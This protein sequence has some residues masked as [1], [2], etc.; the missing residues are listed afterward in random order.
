MKTLPW[1]H[2]MSPIFPAAR[3]TER[4]ELNQNEQN[5][6]VPAWVPPVHLAF[7]F[8]YSPPT[9][10]RTLDRLTAYPEPSRTKLQ[11]LLRGYTRSVIMDAW[12][13]QRKG[14]VPVDEVAAFQAQLVL[15]EPQTKGQE[16]LH[17]T[18][19]RQFNT[20]YEYRRTRLYSVYWINYRIWKG[21]EGKDA[22]GAIRDAPCKVCGFKTSPAHDRRAHHSQRKKR[23]F[24]VAELQELAYTRI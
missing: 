23:A 21:K 18:A 8:S 11:D 14:I 6:G 16:A 17:E 2:M 5:F 19:L 10:A 4:L 22:R 12:P 3:A 9:I 1:L 7:V 20:F 15:F 13:L 24:T